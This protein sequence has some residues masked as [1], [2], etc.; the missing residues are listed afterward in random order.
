MLQ[1]DICPLP[2]QASH[3]KVFHLQKQ[4]VCGPFTPS[5]TSGHNFEFYR[6]FLAM[7]RDSQ[8]LGNKTSWSSH[9]G[10]RVGSAELLFPCSRARSS[11]TCY[12]LKGICH[13]SGG[14]T[15]RDK[16]TT[17]A[18]TSLHVVT[19]LSRNMGRSGR[20]SNVTAKAQDSVFY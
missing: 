16:N 3:I 7:K 13:S 14:C 5:A 20:G 4:S 17:F 15:V 2:I 10:A 18:F 19:K 12:C 1:S 9:S 6:S 11:L 8:G